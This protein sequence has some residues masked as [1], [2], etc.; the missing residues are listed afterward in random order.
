[1]KC[2]KSKIRSKL[3]DG[4]LYSLL[5]LACSIIQADIEMRSR[6]KQHKKLY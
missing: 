5:R 6:Q 4:D 2:I 3:T 1:M